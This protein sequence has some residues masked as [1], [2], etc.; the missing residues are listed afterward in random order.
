ME[1][2]ETI[3]FKGIEGD[4]EQNLL[5]S[6]DNEI[7]LIAKALS[8]STRREILRLVRA[9]EIDVSKIAEYLEM[10][11]A[12]ISAQIKRLEKA[13]LIRCF[14]TPGQHGVKKI[15]KVT[16]NKLIFKI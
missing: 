1:F 7:E 15:S 13:G 5:V 12:N 14:Y 9:E 2:T 6:D 16:F 11:E 3:E 4:V 8:S 10:T